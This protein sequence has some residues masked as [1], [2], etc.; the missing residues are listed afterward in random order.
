MAFAED[1]A[2]IL[3]ALPNVTVQSP[4]PALEQFAGEDLSAFNVGGNLNL[5]FGDHA[6]TTGNINLPFG[7]DAVDVET[8]DSH[9][10]ATEVSHFLNPE[11]TGKLA[12]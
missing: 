3:E 10:K 9:D 5:P 6:I 1:I 12:G 11:I 7:E 4:F 2:T 8:T